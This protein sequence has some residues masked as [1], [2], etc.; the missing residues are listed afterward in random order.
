M[1][2]RFEEVQ[3]DRVRPNEANIREDMGDMVSLTA[4]LK[5]IGI[6]N[7]LLVYPHPLVEGDFLVQ[8]GHRRLQAARDNGALFVP[9]LVVDAPK[10]GL[11]ED[12]EVMLSTGRAAKVLNPLEV[13]FGFEQLVADGMDETTI[14]KKYK[15]P[16]SEV[17]ARAR[18]LSQPKKLQDRFAAGQVDLVT[19]K[20]IQELEDS[21]A[22]EVFDAVVAEVDRRGDNKW[23]YDVEKLIVESERDVAVAAVKAELDGAGAVR[24]DYNMPY[25]GKHDKV[26]DSLSVEGHVEA[27][28]KYLFQHGT[29]SVYW[30]EK[31]VVAK[32]VVSAEEIAEKQIQRS[33]DADLSIQ[34]RVRQKFLIDQVIAKDGGAG[35]TADFDLLFTLMWDRIGRADDE[36]LATLSGITEPVEPVEP[37]DVDNYDEDTV[38][39][40]WLARVKKQF[41][42]FTWQQLA[43]AA[44]VANNWH[45]DDSLSSVKGFDRD[46][47]EWA[48]HR[49]WLT[50]VQESFGYRLDETERNAVLWGETRGGTSRHPFT[51]D[52]GLNR[53]VSED[54]VIIDDEA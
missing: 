19:M 48:T 5:T 24:G 14:G 43:R 8:D 16:K 9:C 41:R 11:R 53:K 39:D 52:E 49:D 47:Y 36:L 6:R 29:A 17:V 21:G 38:H 1:S 35:A 13:S 37:D 7:P 10:R 50:T 20:R 40:E 4:E 3:I 2:A 54:L 31:R 15:I 26:E 22:T 51:N 27:G 23:N 18:V 12:V 25:D 34:G 42:K 32:P 44:A 33:L 28:H 46:K 45:N 30:Y